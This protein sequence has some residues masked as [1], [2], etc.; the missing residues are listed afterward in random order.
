MQEHILHIKLMNGPQ[1]RDDQGEYGADRNRLDHRAEGL[2]IVDGGSLGE[3]T[4]NPSSLVQ[5]QRAVKIEL[6]VENP[7]VGDDIEANGARD[8]IS[9]VVSDQGSKFFF[10][11][12][13]PIRIDKGG[14]D[15]GGHR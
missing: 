11:G 12:V 3:A 14:T 5:F 10:H 6:V 1:A 15:G 4:K 9:G 7:L 8:K 13:A 2:I